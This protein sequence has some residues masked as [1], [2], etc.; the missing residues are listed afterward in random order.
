MELL[1]LSQRAQ[2]LTHDFPGAVLSLICVRPDHQRK[3]LATRLVNEGIK[4][5][6]ERCVKIG[7]IAE[8]DRVK[9]LCESLDFEVKD[10]HTQ[11]LREQGVNT[12]YKIYVLTKSPDYEIISS[13][14]RP[15]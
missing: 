1:Q 2:L 9:G 12:S 10:S 3:G 15:T 8:G 13:R 5:A 14:P 4:I 7:V 6:N 11:D